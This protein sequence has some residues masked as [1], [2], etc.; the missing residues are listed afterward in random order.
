[1]WHYTALVVF[2]LCV[3]SNPQQAQETVEPREEPSVPWTHVL[4]TPA[5]GQCPGNGQLQE[6]AWCCLCGFDWCL[7]SQPNLELEPTVPNKG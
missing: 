7:V 5:R 2:E 1:M 3:K 6:G 4:T